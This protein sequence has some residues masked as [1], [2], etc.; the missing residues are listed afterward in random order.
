MAA[1]EKISNA[2]DLN[3]SRYVKNLIRQDLNTDSKPLAA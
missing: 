2:D 3:W 1:N